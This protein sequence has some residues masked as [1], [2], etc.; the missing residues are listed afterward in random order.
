MHNQ[1]GPIHQLTKF[2]M[3]VA[4]PQTQLFMLGWKRQPTR[5][6]VNL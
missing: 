3:F 4:P 2:L 6:M 1:Q 5:E